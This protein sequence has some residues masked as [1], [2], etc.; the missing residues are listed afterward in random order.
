[1]KSISLRQ[2][3]NNIVKRCIKCNRKLSLEKFGKD[4]NRKDGFYPWC[5][6][7]KNQYGREKY[8]KYKER[9]SKR[10]K[11]YQKENKEIIKQKNKKHRQENL[12]IYRKRSIEFY[13]KN[14][15][16]IKKKHQ[17]YRLN[18]KEKI[19]QKNK[20]YSFKNKEKISQ[21]AKQHNRSLQGR[22]MRSKRLY[23]VSVSDMLEWQNYKCA[24]CQQV[25]N[26]R[27]LSID[28]C[29]KTGQVR[30]LLCGPCN[31][32]GGIIDNIELLRARIE[33]LEVYKSP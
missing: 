6:E 10:Q 2:I 18:N 29:H 3:N 4:Q 33:Y 21:Y 1:M 8:P 30:M 15:N 7:C 9:I 32:G 23:G 27:Q 31:H 11:Q 26:G 17:L 12:E 13:L 28:H 25:E 16:N 5:K 24:I 19:K 22:D 20:I 14:K